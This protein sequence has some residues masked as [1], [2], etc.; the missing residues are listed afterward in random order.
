MECHRKVMDLKTYD[1][2]DHAALAVNAKVLLHI[3]LWF[4]VTETKFSVQKLTK[5][6]ALIKACSGRVITS[7]YTDTFMIYYYMCIYIYIYII[8]WYKHIYI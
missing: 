8:V 7:F 2:S 6:S 4:L 3:G 5:K 1:M